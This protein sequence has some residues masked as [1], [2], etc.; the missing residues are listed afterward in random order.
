MAKTNLEMYKRITKD[1][2]T[3]DRKYTSAEEEGTRLK[4]FS[5]LEPVKLKYSNGT[6]VSKSRSK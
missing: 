6:T 1:V 3:P 2:N 4:P 5:L